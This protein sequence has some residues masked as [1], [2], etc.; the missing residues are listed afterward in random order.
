MA[1]L[2]L[3]SAR[4]FITTALF[5]IGSRVMILMNCHDSNPGLVVKNEN[6]KIHPS[7]RPSPDRCF[8]CVHLPAAVFGVY[9]VI[10][11]ASQIIA[12]GSKEICRVSRWLEVSRYGQSK[13]TAALL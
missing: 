7:A 4:N 9:V 11:V 5:P 3:V 8:I 6:R 10:N 1:V 2:G 12:T 13:T